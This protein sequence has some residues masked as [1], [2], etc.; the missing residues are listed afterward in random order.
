[1]KLGRQI[2]L[3]GLLCVPFS[4]HA[5]DVV[6]ELGLHVGGD[7]IV[8]AATSDGDETVTAGGGYSLAAGAKFDLSE[9]L[10]MQLTGGIKEDAINGSNGDIEFS[11]NTLDLLFHTK[12]T[13]TV[14]LGFGPTWH[15]NVRLSTEGAGG[16]YAADTDFDNALGLLVDGKI[17][18]GTVGSFFLGGRLTFIEYETSQ[19]TLPK[20]TYSGNSVGLMVGFNF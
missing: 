13:E 2:M 1:M 18:L 11:R 17:E 10:S 4:S 5:I 19:N 7:D 3:V 15:S 6:L 9:T 20:K 14:S 8:T 16:F 12:L